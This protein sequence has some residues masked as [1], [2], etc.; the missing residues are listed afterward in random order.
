MAKKNNIK[1]RNFVMLISFLKI[2][3]A[4]LLL[5]ISFVDNRLQEK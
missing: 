3:L 2:S 4:N 5:P 1:T